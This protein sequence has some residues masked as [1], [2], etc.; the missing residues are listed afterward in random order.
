M[1]LQQQAHPAQAPASAPAFICL[2]PGQAAVN[3]L[4]DST[5]QL[6]GGQ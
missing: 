1:H 6:S 5:C 2:P 4:T 3:L